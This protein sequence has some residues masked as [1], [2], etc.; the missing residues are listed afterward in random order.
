MTDKITTDGQWAFRYRPTTP[1]KILTIEAYG[2]QPV[3]AQEIGAHRL[4]FRYADGRVSKGGDCEFDLVPLQ[5]EPLRGFINVYGESGRASYHSTAELAVKNA[6]PLA[7]R[8]AV[9]MVEV[10]AS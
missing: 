10:L 3:I 1:I 6:G 8:V 5:R 7:L 4:Y 9:E 2:A